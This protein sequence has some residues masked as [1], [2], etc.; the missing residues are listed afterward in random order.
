M[1][2]IKKGYFV[3]V[4]TDVFGVVIK[5]TDRYFSVR[6]EHGSIID[7]PKG[8]CRAATKQEV[9]RIIKIRCLDL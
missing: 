9:D 2:K 6:L 8:M 7:Y 1:R 3:A 5:I 4:N